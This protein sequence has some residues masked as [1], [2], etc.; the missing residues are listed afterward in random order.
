MSEFALWLILS[1]SGGGLLLLVITAFLLFSLYVA[2]IHWKYSHI[3][4]PKMNSFFLGHFPDILN[5]RKQSRN[6][7]EPFTKMFAKWAEEKGDLFVVFFAFK[8]L[9]VSINPDDV[10][11]LAYNESVSK[12]PMNYESLSTLFG[13]RF[14]GQGLLT[15]L[16]YAS[17]KPRR[18][19]YNSSFKR[20]SLKDLLPMFNECVDTFLEGLRPHA[21][22]K[23]EVSMK[24]AF[25]E[26]ALDVISK[27]AFSSDFSKTWD[28]KSLGL[29]YTTNSMLSHLSSVGLKG[30]RRSFSVGFQTLFEL[31]Y[32]HET[33]TYRE[34]VTAMRR[35]GRDCIEK[36]IKA[37]TSGEEVPND[38]LTQILQT[39]IAARLVD[40]ETLVDDFVTFYVADFL[41]EIADVLGDRK[42]VTADDLD[43]LKYTEQIEA[44]VVLTRLL[45]TFKVTLPPSY[46]LVVEQLGTN[47][48]KGDVP[49][50][51]QEVFA[52]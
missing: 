14:M 21:D 27:V 37:V 17:W 30:V 46:K 32:P 48:P 20:S 40:M 1:Y 23:T 13:T 8:P 3:P 12:S 7:F 49:C 39:S 45:Q 9:V 4:S 19:L 35:I 44:K 41:S 24:E 33:E 18:K 26:V 42:E 2:Y 10:Q 22:G 34:A 25:H 36:R 15:I 16:D 43:K 47:Q 52:G 29:K 11:R 5:M 38:I 50:T 6:E 51:L 28:H 31:L